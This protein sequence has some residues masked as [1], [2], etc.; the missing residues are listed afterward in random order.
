MNP[1][2]RLLMGVV[3][4]VLFTA[5]DVSAQDMTVSGTVT[6]AQT[7][8]PL[9]G[10]NVSVE[11][12]TVG[13]STDENGHYQL[14]GPDDAYTLVF[15][16][17]GYERLTVEVEERS[18]IDVELEPSVEQLDDLVVTS[19]GVEQEKQA[20]GYAVQEIGGESVA[21]KEQPNVINALRGQVSGVSI[22][23][24]GGNPGQSSRIV[25]RGINSLDPGADNQPLFVVD[26]V[27]INNSTYSGPNSSESFAYSNRA[28]DINPDDIESISVLK[29]GA[30]TALY[31][32][33]AANGAVIITT[34]SGSAGSTKVEFSS[35]V[36]FEEVN[37]Y[38]EQQKQF[39]GG[40]YGEPGYQ[41]YSWPFHAWGP[42]ADTV[43]GARFYDNLR[44]F[45][46]Y[47][48]PGRQIKN[49][50]NVSGGTDKA[51]FYISASDLNQ[52]GVTPG[53][54]FSKSTAKLSGELFISDRL[55]I[56]GS[57]NY[58]KSGGTKTPQGSIGPV[59]QLY[60]TPTSEDVT[61][62]INEDGTQK[63][64]TPWLDNPIYRA[65]N[66][67]MEDDVNRIFGNL[68]VDFDV[69]DW[70]NINYR[71]GN[72]F[73]NDV[74]NWVIPGPR[75][76]NDTNPLH[77]QG[78]IQKTSI[79]N[80][81]L[82]STLMASFTRDLS[83]DVNA[84]FRIGND[85][86]SS[87]YD[88][89]TV[90]GSEFGV[91]FFYDL[92]NVTTITTSERR[93]E[94]RVAGIYGDLNLDYKNWLYLNIT[95]RN[96]WSSTLPK[97][98][99]SFFYPSASLGFVFSDL[100][101]LPDFFDYGKLRGSWSQLGKDAPAYSTG[102]KYTSPDNFPFNG[103]SGFTK[104]DKLGDSNLKPEITTSIEFG[105]DLRFFNNR[106]GVD[107]TWYK[108]NSKDQIIN[109]PVSNTTGFTTYLTNAGEIQNQGI[110]TVLTVRAIESSDFSW[111][112][113]SNFTKNNNKV[114][115]IREGIESIELFG[116]SYSYG[117]SLLIQL[118]EG[119]PYGNIMG[120]S[121]K[122]YYENPEN[123][124]PLF[125]DEDRPILIGDDGFPVRE[126]NYKILG[127]T[128]PDWT[129]GIT[130]TFHYK[131]LSLSFLVDIKKGGDVYNQPEAFF[132]AQGLSMETLNRDQEKV[133]E[134]VTA[135][136][137]PNTK[138]VYL[139]Q[140]E[141][142]GE[143]YGDGYYRNVWRKVASN[144]VEDASWIRLR[145]LNFTY[146][147]PSRL[148]SNTLLRNASLSFTGNNLLLFTPYSGFDPEQSAYGAG[149]NTQGFQGRGTPAVRSMSLSLK[150]SM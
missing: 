137:Q 23:S 126:L 67:Q 77:A 128:T 37:K 65:K 72:D 5:L 119:L 106:V 79:N 90:D 74:R 35:T 75:S 19:F 4:F 26:G 15:T 148:I 50:I 3:I 17:V 134:G 117:G 150:L 12:T 149:S 71:L 99:R 85:I 42:K 101:E 107:L 33:R 95:G 34:K 66:N 36:G 44:N 7:G 96:D 116:S 59:S 81:E 130:N 114:I 32:I 45:F 125:V 91:P 6:D 27:P 115:S 76:A 109:V 102:I 31:G 13:T 108:S 29:S 55:N 89:L 147:L 144:F 21:D 83:E 2:L 70:F 93:T 100:V 111:D 63:S 10:V 47:D 61:D 121:Y 8:E 53:T 28:V 105:T 20:L 140:G 80:R 22:N 73:Y 92:S 1:Y 138:R 30:A 142:N 124:D 127:N 58:T 98:N 145:S 123:E 46:E 97:D 68:A 118:F 62:W 49:S 18:T 64:Y 16:F 120:T 11:N 136:G 60:Y 146:N 132:A 94:K 41:S 56:S 69:T 25:I 135:D 78:Y 9:P 143:W 122:R 110:E 57:V 129:A 133:F 87:T 139:G 131:N 40:W 103:N 39:M 82:T 14:S 43:S 141:Y 54:D 48:G 38:P 51:T 88:R 113:K 86:F 84:S 52:R 104:N 24:S 112:I